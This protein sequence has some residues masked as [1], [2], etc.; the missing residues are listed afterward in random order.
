MKSNL[1]QTNGHSYIIRLTLNRAIV[2]IAVFLFSCMRIIL[3][4]IYRSR[5]DKATCP[6][7]DGKLAWLSSEVR[8][9]K[10]S[11]TLSFHYFMHSSRVEICS[12]RDYVPASRDGIFQ[13][14]LR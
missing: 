12:Y 14:G 4:M 1:I 6:S 10:G 9:S 13:R 3:R 7:L 2:S 8:L 11:L 5:L